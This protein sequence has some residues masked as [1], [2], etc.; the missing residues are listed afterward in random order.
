MSVTS[1]IDSRRVLSVPSRFRA[2]ESWP[3]RVLS[4]IYPCR[5]WG[6]ARRASEVEQAGKR[7][8]NARP[9]PGKPAGY[10]TGETR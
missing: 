9:T 7:A 3:S 6:G 4:W 5:G 2:A 10:R 8:K 1:G